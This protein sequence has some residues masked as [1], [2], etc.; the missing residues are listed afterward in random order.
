MFAKIIDGK[1]IAEEVKAETSK[2]VKELVANGIV[3]GLAT[4]L[5]GENPASRIYL[6]NKHAACKAIGIESTNHELPENSSTAQVLK[7]IQ[8][9]NENPKVHGI[10]VQL[11]LPLQVNI[12]KVLSAISPKKDVDGFH[13]ENLGKLFA[14]KDSEEL[15]QKENFFPIPCTPQGVLHLILKTGI[16]LAQKNA[17]VIGRS[18]IVG[19]PT[20]AL[21]L[22]HHATVTVAHSRTKDLAGCCRQADVVVA[23]IGKAKF[24]TADFIKEGAVVIDVGINRGSD[25]KIW[26]DVDFDSVKEKAGWITPVPGGVGPMTIAMLLKNTVQLAKAS[27]NSQ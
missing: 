12:E 2:E 19:K 3:P 5:V 25:G 27:S 22:A 20:A 13:P 17:V 10:L 24:I 4:L 11:P 23:A 7:R 15:N 18:T 6:K 21:L 9:L 14:A 26:G 1:Q 8:E 16:S